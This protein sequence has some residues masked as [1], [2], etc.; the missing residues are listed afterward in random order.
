MVS[1]FLHFFTVSLIFHSTSF[2][3]AIKDAEAIS[4]QSFL[5]LLSPSTNHYF[6]SYPN[7]IVPF[8]SLHCSISRYR[9]HHR[10]PIQEIPLFYRLPKQS[11]SKEASHF[12]PSLTKDSH[13]YLSSIVIAASLLEFVIALNVPLRKVILFPQAFDDA[14]NPDLTSKNSIS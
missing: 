2:T 5:T 3:F 1:P 7:S 9:N 10:I 14:W 12:E 4:I 6:L 13:F 11:I 8:T